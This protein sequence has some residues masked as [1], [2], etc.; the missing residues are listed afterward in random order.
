M[1]IS[2]LVYS[3]YIEDWKQTHGITRDIE[4]KNMREYYCDHKDNIYNQTFGNAYR[5]YVD[6]E[7]RGFGRYV[8]YHEFMDAEYNEEDYIK[9]L[10]QDPVL[11]K[12]YINDLH[13]RQAHTD[14]VTHGTFQGLLEYL[15]F[16]TITLDNDGL[17]VDTSYQNAVTVDCRRS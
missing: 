12:E 1:D 15:N 6:T 9:D 11:I 10:L 2:E 8:S 13:R 17:Y 5:N 14:S 16:P 7:Y 3:L 4:M